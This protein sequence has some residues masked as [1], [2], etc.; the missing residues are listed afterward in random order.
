M[1]CFFLLR[2]LEGQASLIPPTWGVL[3]ALG[4]FIDRV[5]GDGARAGLSGCTV[6]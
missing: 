6:T 5:S 4:V 3:L 1:V 2:C